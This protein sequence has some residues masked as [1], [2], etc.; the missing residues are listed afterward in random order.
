[1][2]AVECHV[3]AKDGVESNI[4]RAVA[5]R[6]LLHRLERHEPTLENIFLHYVGATQAATE[7]AA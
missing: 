7:G 1:M 6:W 5:S 2:L 4:A 3:D